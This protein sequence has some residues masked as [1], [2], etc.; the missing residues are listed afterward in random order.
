MLRYTAPEIEVLKFRRED[1]LGVSPPWTWEDGDQDD[2]KGGGTEI[3]DPGTVFS[4]LDL[5]MS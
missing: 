3:D 5:I 2:G 1:I 4:I